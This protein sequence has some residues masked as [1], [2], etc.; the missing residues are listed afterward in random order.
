MERAVGYC[1]FSSDMQREESITAQMRAINEFAN[2]NNI[3]MLKFYKDHAQSG[4]SDA[5]DDFQLMMDEVKDIDYVIVHKFDRFARNSFDHVMNERKLND[6]GI[7]LIS[8]LEPVGDNPESVLTKSLLIGLNEYFSLN[9]SRE[10]KKGHKENALKAKFNGGVP[11][12]GYKIVDGDYVIDE[13]EAQIVRSVF[14]L[15]LQGYSY[16]AIADVLNSNGFTNKHG[17]PFNRNSFTE[18]LKNKRYKGTY[19][20]GVNDSR[21]T[22]RSSRKKNKEWIELEDAIPAIV[23]KEMWEEV[24]MNRKK[25]SGCYKKNARDYLLSGLVY[26]DKCGAPMLGCSRKSSTGKIYYYYRCNDRCGNQ[27]IR[28]D[29][30]EDAV[31][32]LIRDTLITKDNI[33]VLIN[34]I[35]EHSVKNDPYLDL[36]KKRQQLIRQRDNII[37]LMAETGSSAL[38]E[39]LETLDEQIDNIK[40]PVFENKK[41]DRDVVE[42]QF[43]RFLEE[44]LTKSMIKLLIKKI[45]INNQSIVINLQYYPT[46]LSRG[47]NDGAGNLS[48]ITYPRTMKFAA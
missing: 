22:K 33:N 36:R 7:K 11:P 19:I 10:V 37:N 46:E 29:V 9:L 5:R 31:T 8:V 35:E 32:K 43:M 18:M 20:Y 41:F 44:P 21:G 24:N 23:S 26:C 30:L 28:A 25:R 39:K 38:I 3:E 14:T 27:S 2:N 12:L 6:K 42:K 15:R 40:V 1:R 16:Q 13:Q 17:K 45:K 48:L 4:T 47:Y 34:Y